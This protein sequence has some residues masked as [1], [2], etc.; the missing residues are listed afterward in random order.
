MRT[1]LDSSA[2]LAALLDEPGGARAAAEVGNAA[3]SSVNLAE[4][5][6][7]LARHGNDGGQVRAI[8]AGTPILMVAPDEET[9]IDA[10]LLRAMTDRAGLSLGDRFCLALARQR[11]APVLTA[12]R[13][14]L[15]I[16]EAVGVEIELIR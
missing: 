15:E 16:A 10:G 13:N 9:A 2:L 6:A 7:R 8:I 3:M 1:V 4:V 5:V 12:D 11:S 14:W